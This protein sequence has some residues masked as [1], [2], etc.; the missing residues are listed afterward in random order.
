MHSNAF[1]EFSG[2]SSLK[3]TVILI[4]D[5]TGGLG[6]PIVACLSAQKTRLYPGERNPHASTEYCQKTSKRDNCVDR[7]REWESRG[8]GERARW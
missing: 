1:N 3:D 4:A 7:Y 5:K 2:A 8:N 6:L